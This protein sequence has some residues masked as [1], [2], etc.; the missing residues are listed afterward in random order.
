MNL[1]APETE[2]A[3]G[4]GILKRERQVKPSF[5]PEKGRT[6]PAL[7]HL[8]AAHDQLPQLTPLWYPRYLL[9]PLPI[10]PTLL[11]LN[12]LIECFNSRQIAQ[13]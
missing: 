3:G 7:A 12:C 8:L 11:G 10:I 9:F 13:M 1:R 6:H 2:S 5:L 4:A